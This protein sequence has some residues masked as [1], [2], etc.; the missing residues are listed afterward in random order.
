MDKKI[1]YDLKMYLE[2]AKK[3]DWFYDWKKD[4][5]PNIRQ[6]IVELLDKY[7]EYGDNY[8][9][10]DFLDSIFLLRNSYI[11][12]LEPFDM[13]KYRK[14]YS[15]LQQQIYD[16]LF[17]E[18]FSDSLLKRIPFAMNH[19]FMEQARPTIADQYF[20][21]LFNRKN[22]DDISDID[23]QEVV[24]AYVA[25][26]F[27]EEMKRPNFK[28]LDPSVENKI[29]E[30]NGNTIVI[31]SL[32]FKKIK[33][34]DYNYINKFYESIGTDCPIVIEKNNGVIK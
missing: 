14:S 5:N 26:Q 34:K 15:Q 25:E 21:T 7:K 23:I 33:E 13:Y 24:C 6:L 30:I 4:E 9:P 31:N 20:I 27:H 11:T 29:I 28:I 22:N 18:N 17:D 3:N 12:E 16:E 1:V 19:V 2:T 10:C 8:Y 32:L